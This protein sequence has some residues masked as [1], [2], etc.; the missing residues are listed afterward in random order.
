M[1]PS[2]V[3]R[4]V[5]SNEEKFPR[6]GQS[7]GPSKVFV[8]SAWPALTNLRF[9]GI[10]S[11]VYWNDLPSQLYYDRSGNV[12]AAGA[13]VLTESIIETALREGWTKAE[14]CSYNVS[15]HHTALLTRDIQVEA[16]SAPRMLG[17]VH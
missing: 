8:S 10:N 3:F 1:R 15:W 11:K 4:T 12:R 7:P 17:I 2:V 5:F 16:S 9:R 6:F 13:E 14:W